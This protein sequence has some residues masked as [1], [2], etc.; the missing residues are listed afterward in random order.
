MRL[1]RVRLSVRSLMVL[2]LVIG[3]GLGGP[4]HRAQGQSDAV[5]AI[6]RAG[7]KVAYNGPGLP[8]PSGP[9]WVRRTLG[10]DFLD[11]VTYVNLQGA[12]CDDQA[13]RAACRLPWL[14]ELVVVNTGVT[15]EGAEDLG[16]L[17]RLRSL[18]YRL[19]RT[20]PRPLRHIAE[21]TELR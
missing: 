21:M 11:T 3:V 12:Q 5:A 14:E 4:I 18:D 19:N 13:L 17:R 8:Q 2:V 7:G 15:D 9:D 10:P 6:K 1:P 20:T 16:K